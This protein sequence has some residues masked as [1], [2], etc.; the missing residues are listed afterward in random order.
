MN[1]TNLKKEFREDAIDRFENQIATYYYTLQQYPDS[2]VYI[3]SIC[4]K[5]GMP[6][7]GID[8]NDE[9][10]IET[11]VDEWK[12][13][14]FIVRHNVIKDGEVIVEGKEV[15]ACVVKDPNSSKGFKA[16]TFPTDVIAKFE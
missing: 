16:T 7:Y 10:E 12:G 3:E 4:P 9:V 14:I 5:K 6:Q 2:I 15:R 13:K 8:F 11:W 1:D